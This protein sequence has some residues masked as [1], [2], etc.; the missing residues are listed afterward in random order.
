MTMRQAEQM[1]NRAVDV[2]AKMDNEQD[3]QTRTKLQQELQKILFPVFNDIHWTEEER[4]RRKTDGLEDIPRLDQL[5]SISV[6]TMIQIDAAYV[7]HVHPHFS[8]LGTSHPAYLQGMERYRHAVVKILNDAATPFRTLRKLQRTWMHRS[9]LMAPVRAY[10]QLTYLRGYNEVVPF[11]TT[12]VMDDVQKTFEP[13]QDGIA[14]VSKIH[15][16]SFQHVLHKALCESRLM[17][18]SYIAGGPTM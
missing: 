7:N 6:E 14:E 11:P 16:P 4:M 13:F 8:Y 5:K 17:G 10:I 18:T 12:T 3:R 15:F 2:Q 1:M 9:A